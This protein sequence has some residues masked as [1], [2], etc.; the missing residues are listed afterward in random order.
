MQGGRLRRNK[1]VVGAGTTKQRLTPTHIGV[2]VEKAFGKRDEHSH[3]PCC[4]GAGGTHPQAYTACWQAGSLCL[5][6]LSSSSY[7]QESC[8]CP[9]RHSSRRCLRSRCQG[10]GAV[11]PCFAAQ[12]Q[13]TPGPSGSILRAL[14]GG[15]AGM[16][17]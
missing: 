15:A 11:L 17:S 4:I 12:D 3:I 14:T 13:T 9:T 2:Q 5:G 1:E 10:P 16:H 7:E 8:A 6:F